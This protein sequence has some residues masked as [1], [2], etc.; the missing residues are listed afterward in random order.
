MQRRVIRENAARGNGGQGM[1]ASWVVARRLAVTV[2]VLTA[3]HALQRVPLPLVDFAALPPGPGTSRVHCSVAALGVFPLV[4]AFLAVEWVAWAIP[5][6]APLRFVPRGRAKLERASVVLSVVFAAFQGFAL[7]I[8]MEGWAPLPSPV[9]EP[10]WGF[11]SL[12]ILTLATATSLHYLALRLIDRAG[13]GGGFSVVLGVDAL[14]MATVL[15]TEG[16]AHEEGAGRL[17]FVGSVCVTLLVVVW[18][19]QLKWRGPGNDGGPGATQI[20][21]TLRGLPGG[22]LPLGLT[23]AILRLLGQAVPLSP[24]LLPVVE[25]I[26]VAVAACLLPFILHDPHDVAAV[27][28]S[29]FPSVA[30]ADARALAM[31]RLAAATAVSA[32]ALVGLTWF[33]RGVTPVGY[34]LVTGF[35]LAPVAAVLL[36]VAAEWRAR[37]RLGELVVVRS[38]HRVYEADTLVELL[39]QEGIPA[40]ARSLHHRS[41]FHFFAPHLP[42]DICVPEA[43]REVASRRLAVTAPAIPPG[44]RRRGRRARAESQTAPGAA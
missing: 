31:R 24:D 32:L 23:Q 11:R 19:L 1:H 8:L 15:L 41:L 20:P 17:A 7:A 34:P 2:G 14:S 35:L 26:S 43:D 16:L 21:L 30:V 37:A 25:L 29:A 22:I 4:N 13:L 38:V 12:V 10:G 40:H 9:V 42:I 33:V 6:L 28:T 3:L 39:A 5:S 18:L 36:D 44:R 27:H